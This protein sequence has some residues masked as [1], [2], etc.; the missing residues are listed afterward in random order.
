MRLAL[1]LLGALIALAVLARCLAPS[2]RALRHRTRRR[3]ARKALRQLRRL[4][5]LPARLAFLRSINPYAFEEL[6]LS[7]FQRRGARIYRNRSYSG[8]GGADGA[9]SYQGRFF[10]LQAKRYRGHISPRDILRFARLLERRGCHGF[11]CHTGRTGA[12]ARALAAQHPCLTILSGPAL[13]QLLLP[14]PGAAR[15]PPTAPV[16]GNRTPRT[17]KHSGSALRS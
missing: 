17:A 3:Q 5:G 8:D 14:E 12:S 10:L 16:A 13:L 1:V 15:P 11:F 2:A 9:L 6:L 7:A 4:R